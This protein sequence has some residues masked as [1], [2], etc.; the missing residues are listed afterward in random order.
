MLS[1]PNPMVIFT[2]PDLVDHFVAERRRRGLMDRT[3]VFGM[4]VYCIPY[5]WLLEP[6]TRLMCSADFSRGAAY[7]EIPERQQPFYNLIM[8]AKTL[9]L[10]AAATLPFAATN[11]SY[12]TWLDL[13]CHP[14]MCDEAWMGAGAGGGEVGR[15]LDPS[16]WARRDR[17]R[18]AIT[19]PMSP[20]VW[21]Q[22]DVTWAK[23]SAPPRRLVH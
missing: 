5:A 2:S 17:I 14:P 23:A 6:V 11:A 12:M 1:L 7:L 15:C 22:D 4:S 9:F 8:Y 13:G 20:A 21:A 3:A 19:A 16:P 18:I 10:K